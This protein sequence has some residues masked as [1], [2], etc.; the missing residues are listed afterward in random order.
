MDEHYKKAL[1]N[2][3]EVVQQ[4]IKI[5][6]DVVSGESG[7]MGSFRRL[8][9]AC[10]CLAETGLNESVV[11]KMGGVLTQEECGIVVE[12]MGPVLDR[13]YEL[14]DEFQRARHEAR[15]ESGASGISLSGIREQSEAAFSVVSDFAER[16]SNRMRLKQVESAIAEG[17]AQ[18]AG[19]EDTQTQR[20]VAQGG[21]FFGKEAEKCD[22]VASKWGGMVL[23]AVAAFI[24]CA[25][26]VWRSSGPEDV[27]DGFALVLTLGNR[28]LLFIA[29]GYG[30]FFC[31]K[32][33]MAY[34]HNAV[35]NRHRENALETYL[36]VANAVKDQKHRDTMLA[37][38]AQCIYVPQDSGFARRNSGSEISADTIIRLARGEKEG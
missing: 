7:E 22:A 4:T 6:E 11:E 10:R 19:V 20:S 5:S 29:L 34:R 8:T 38:A 13:L 31:A 16:A 21:N 37:Y 12:K 17:K 30:V 9:D 28:A 18:L 33:Y 23:L 36:A 27:A 35:V 25:I 32:N 24:F 1:Q 26:A 2:A 3:S 15:N 14:K